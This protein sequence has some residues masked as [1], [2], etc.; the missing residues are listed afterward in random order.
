M[1]TGPW[2]AGSITTLAPLSTLRTFAFLDAR[3]AECDRQQQETGEGP[4]FDAVRL[5]PVQ[6]ATNVAGDHRWPRWSPAALDVGIHRALTLRLVTNNTSGTLNLYATGPGKIEHSI[7]R[8]A[9]VVAAYASMLLAAI[10]TEDQLRQ[11]V[12]TRGLIGQAQ[13]ILMQQFGIDAAGAFAVLRRTSQQHNVKIVALA[14]Q[15]IST[16]IL[17][18]LT[19]VGSSPLR[20]QGPWKE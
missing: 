7:V 4:A 5:D 6:T 3:A 15:L 19:N 1:E 9:E 2:A 18:G 14:E 16:G 11:A 20:P 12:S 8:D 17:P 13:G 10:I